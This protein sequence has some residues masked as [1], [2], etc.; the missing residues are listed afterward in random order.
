MSDAS[1]QSWV[2][3][4][5]KCAAD[6]CS[7]TARHELQQFAIVRF[8]KHA[9]TE[10]YRTNDPD[11]YVLHVTPGEAMH[12]L[13]V[14]FRAHSNRQG[15]RYKDWLFARTQHTDDKPIDVIQGFSTDL[16]REVV[17][18]F[19]RRECP[20]WGLIS[21]QQPLS[22][23]SD[24][25]TLEDLLPGEVDPLGEVESREYE[26]LA[27]HHARSL[28]AHL[29]KREKVALAAKEMGRSLADL[30]VLE[31]AGC[32][33]SVLN[34]AYGALIRKIAAQIQEEHPGEDASSLRYLSERTLA[35]L[36]YEILEESPEK[37]GRNCG[38]Q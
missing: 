4:K 24:S 23:D 11:G 16:M 28:M 9:N 21:L 12:L 6:L 26:E 31:H 38:F 37:P 8:Q 2:E 30:V 29:E 25:G 10:S 32:K 34:A 1:L 7:E 5:E 35:H 36:K 22:R 17:R 18:E 27:A 3:W 14:Y 15:T 33:K 20:R 19:I 13:E